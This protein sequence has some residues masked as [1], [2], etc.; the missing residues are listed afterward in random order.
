MTPS[1]RRWTE[2]RWT[3]DNRI[4]ANGIDWDQP[5]IANLIAACGPEAQADI[6]AIRA[7]VQKFADVGRSSEAGGQIVKTSL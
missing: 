5:R 4:R 1:M 2:Q 7:R 3:V 6:A